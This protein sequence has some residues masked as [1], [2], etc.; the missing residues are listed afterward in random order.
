MVKEHIQSEPNLAGLNK[1]KY[2]TEFSLEPYR[3][4]VENMQ[5][6]VKSSLNDEDEQLLR[7]IKSNQDKTNSIQKA[8]NGL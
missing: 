3:D 7:Q 5:L 8:K 1:D 4:S 6:D 2:K